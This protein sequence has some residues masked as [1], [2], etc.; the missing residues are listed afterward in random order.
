MMPSPINVSGKF[1]QVTPDNSLVHDTTREYLG[2]Y[3]TAKIPVVIVNGTKQGRGKLPPDLIP[4]ESSPHP[5]AESEG[6]DAHKK[7]PTC[8]NDST[9][10]YS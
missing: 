7:V 9:K 6:T 5:T 2:I 1:I 4:R 3:L 10:I 8:R